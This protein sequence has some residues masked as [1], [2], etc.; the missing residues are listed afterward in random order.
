MNPKS[1]CRPLPFL[2][3]IHDLVS[4]DA[5]AKSQEPVNGKE[6]KNGTAAP[7]KRSSNVG[8][9]RMGNLREK[10]EKGQVTEKKK[11]KSAPKIKYAGADAVKSKFIETATK[12]TKVAENGPKGPKEFT[13]PPEGVAVGVLESQPKPRAPDVVTADDTLEPV[14][15]TVIGETTKNLRAKFKHLEE[16]GGQADDEEKPHTNALIDEFKTVGTEA[17]R[18]ARG[19]WKDI[20]SGKVESVDLGE[21]PKIDIR[22]EGYGGVYEN[23]PEK[24]ENIARAGEPK[25][26]LPSGI[27]AK[28]RR[29]E[30]LRKAHE[31]SVV[32]KEPT[33]IDINAAESGI[34][35]NEPARRDDVVRYDDEQ[36]HDYPPTTAKWAS[37][38]KNRFMQEASKAQERVQRTQPVSDTNTSGPGVATQAKQALLEKKKQEE[39]AAKNKARPD[40][41]DIWGEQCAHSGVFE[42]T[43]AA[44]SADVV[45]GHDSEESE[46]EESEEEE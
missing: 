14:D 15:L 10:F 28:E 46:V 44:R 36:T 37:E 6:E 13:P 20:E 5:D 11:K 29:E 4:T 43:P 31:S 18:S 45:A 42:N 3:R 9:E 22:G 26:E 24:F 30:F 21:R 41:I 25:H 27:S 35:E 40:I 12:S 33:K 38:A 32:K 23:E 8:A 2:V 1:H 34:Y 7:E 19:R 39:E 16:T 17:L